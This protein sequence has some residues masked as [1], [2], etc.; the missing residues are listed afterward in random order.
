MWENGVW[1]NG[2]RQT[3]IDTGTVGWRII[4]RCKYLRGIPCSITPIL[5]IPLPSSGFLLPAARVQL[6]VFDVNG[7]EVATLAEGF[8]P[9]GE[10]EM[11][12]RTNG[13]TAGFG[14]YQSAGR[15]SCKIE[16]LANSV[17]LP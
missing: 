11:P 5:S 17:F 6:P 1:V 14:F 7:R 10:Q 15:L 9:A 4:M 2:E 16:L 8:V 13:L 3:S 12:F